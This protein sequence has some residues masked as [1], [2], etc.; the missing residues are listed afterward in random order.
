MAG[1]PMTW[2]HGVDYADLLNRSGS[3]DR[4]RFWYQK[5]GLDLDADLATL[6]RR[7]ASRPSRR[8]WPWWRTRR[9]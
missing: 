9:R 4:V 2:N 6:R 8:P 1:G 5:A 3:L 7:G